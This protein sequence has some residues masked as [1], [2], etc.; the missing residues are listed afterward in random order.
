MMKFK[1]INSE[2][3]PTFKN[4]LKLT[5]A[6]AIKKHGLALLSGPKQ[7]GEVL[8]EF[9]DRCHSLVFSEYHEPPDRSTAGGIPSYRMKGSLFRQ[10]DLY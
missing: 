4:L 1:S 8:E 5:K 10:I 6:R 3:N 9:P 2:N 7:V